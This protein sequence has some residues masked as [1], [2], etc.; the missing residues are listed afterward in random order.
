[1]FHS[2][3]ECYNFFFFLFMFLG[4]DI[5]PIRTMMTTFTTLAEFENKK[6]QTS[7]FLRRFP[8]D[9]GDHSLIAVVSNV[10]FGTL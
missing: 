8:F 4:I 7:L 1:M 3:R 10:I 6:S 2:S 9:T 5:G